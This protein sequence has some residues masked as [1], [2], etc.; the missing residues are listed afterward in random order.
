M[1]RPYSVIIRLTNSGV[2]Q[3]TF[4]GFYLWDPAVYSIVITFLELQVL[5][6]TIKSDIKMMCLL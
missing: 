4:G 3:G 1:F 6:N 5:F 2:S